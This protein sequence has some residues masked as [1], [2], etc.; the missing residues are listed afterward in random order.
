MT[1]P[2]LIAVCIQV[3]VGCW[4]GIAAIVKVADRPRADA[5]TERYTLVPHGLGRAVTSAIIAVE[6]VLCG[7]LVTGML[8]TWAAPLAA[9]VLIGYATAMA[10]DLARG[11]VHACGCGSSDAPIRWHLVARNLVTALALV[12]SSPVSSD[13]PVAI[14][15][16]VAA[17]AIGVSVAII[18]VATASRVWRGVATDG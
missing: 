2:V 18:A 12:V 11:D 15:S 17:T 3:L 8:V 5:A 16:L 6:A 1:P 9:I 10:V 13:I 4:F 7:A 14:H